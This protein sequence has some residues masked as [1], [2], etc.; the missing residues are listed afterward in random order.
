M[1]A[2]APRRAGNASFE[3][4]R[5]EQAVELYTQA[6]ETKVRRAPVPRRALTAPLS[7]TTRS[8]APAC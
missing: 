6:L 3:A 7:P 5:Y 4:G 1:A 8:C 2:D